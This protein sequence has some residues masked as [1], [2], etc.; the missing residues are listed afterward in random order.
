MKS[1]ISPQNY[2]SWLTLFEAAKVR[3]HE[4]ILNVTKVVENEHTP[5]F[6][7]HRGLFTI[8]YDLNTLKRT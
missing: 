8:K 7:Y 4:P 6:Y 2:R 3:Q 1:L 5:M